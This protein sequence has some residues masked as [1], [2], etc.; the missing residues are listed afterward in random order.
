VITFLSFSINAYSENLFPF[1]WEKYYENLEKVYK[2]VLDKEIYLNAL[3]DNIFGTSGVNYYNN[4]DYERVLSIALS[5][6]ERDIRIIS[7]YFAKVLEVEEM[8]PELVAQLSIETN[9]EVKKELI[10]AIGHL[11]SSTEVLPLTQYLKRETNYELQALL[12][13]SL[14]RLGGTGDEVGPLIYLAENSTHFYVKCAAILGI[15]RL[16]LD[17]GKDILAQTMLDNRKEVRFT[18]IL[19]LTF[20]KTE[21]QAITNQLRQRLNEEDSEYVR[22]VISFYMLK[23]KG[24]HRSYAYHLTKYIGHPVYQYPALDFILCLGYSDFLIT[25]KTAEENM[26]N[27]GLKYQVSMVIEILERK[28]FY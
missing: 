11:G 26:N 7:A 5:H 21:D 20:L 10:W 24:Y 17:Q 16:E 3:G 2:P 19:A 13:L 8:V 9:I 15:G 12:A 22:L 27:M 25:L 4:G 1:N 23:W 28:H 18:S 14:G 6:E